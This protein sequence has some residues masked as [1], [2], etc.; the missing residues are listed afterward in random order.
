MY[1]QEIKDQ[2]AKVNK[3]HEA[4]SDIHDIRKQEEVLQESIKMLPDAQQRAKKA[5]EGL[6]QFL[7]IVF[8]PRSRGPKGQKT[9]G[10]KDE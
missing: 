2:E 1:Q 5:A 9:K 4:G 7:G 10:K 3:M 6:E 8:R